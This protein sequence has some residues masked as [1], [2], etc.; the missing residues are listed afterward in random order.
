VSGESGGR[1]YKHTHAEK[2]SLEGGEAGK[3]TLL[4][5][6]VDGGRGGKE[7]SFMREKMEKDRTLS[8]K[9][10]VSAAT[11]LRSWGCVGCA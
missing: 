3:G 4:L 10:E 9:R 7:K 11:Q 5:K 1:E 8:I 2:W 6:E